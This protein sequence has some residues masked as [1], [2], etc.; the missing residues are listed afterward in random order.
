MIWS[1]RHAQTVGATF[2]RPTAKIEF[3]TDDFILPD[4]GTIRLDWSKGEEHENQIYGVLFPGLLGG[5]MSAEVSHHVRY[6]QKNGIKI[7]VFNGRGVKIP[8]TG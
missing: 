8:L 3:E 7:I 6:C 4:G 5:T 2:I 1:N